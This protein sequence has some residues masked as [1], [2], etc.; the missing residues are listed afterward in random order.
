MPTSRNPLYRR[1]RFPSEVISYAVWLYFRFPLSLRMVEEM[2][3]AR[4]IWVTYET[5]PQWGK[6]FGEPFADQICQRAP[7][8]GDKWHMDEVV[9]SIA[10]KQHWLWRAVDQD[11][12]VLGRPSPASKR[13]PHGAAAHG[14]A[15]EIRGHA[16]ARHDHGQ[17][18]V[19]WGC[20]SEVGPYR[21]APPAQGFE[22]S[23]VELSPADKTARTDH[24]AVQII[25]AS[26]TVSIDTRLGRQP[27]S[28]SLPELRL[29]QPS[30]RLT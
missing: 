9:V 3:A 24:E 27:L 6:K 11:G 13:Q 25:P 14:E 10:G 7:A 26:A 29:R 20:E 16:A 15:S 2:L 19:L 30:P 28:R 8:R 18:S 17:A 4:G 22:Q 5:V 12:F 21:G 1:H 23:G